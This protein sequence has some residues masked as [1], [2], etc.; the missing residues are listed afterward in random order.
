M[1]AYVVRR[2]LSGLLLVLLL[3]F[4]TFAVYQLI[5]VNPACLRI[6]CG[7]GNRSTPA[8]FAA[9]DHQLGVDRPLPFQYARWV[10]RF[11]RHGSFGTGW[12]GGV[13]VTSTIGHALPITA[14]IVAGGLLLLLLMAI[15]LGCYAALRPRSP[16]D[17]GLL[18]FGVLGLAIHPFVLAIAIKDLFGYAG[19]PGGGYCALTSTANGCGGPAD[20]GAHLVLPWI[21]F[22]LFFLPIYLRMIRVR[23]LE[24]LGEQYVV[25]ARAKGATEQR[26][27]RHHVL[28][29]AM[30]PLL[31]MVAA[32]AGTALTAA[33][34]IELVFG[35]P[36]L[37]QLSVRSLSGQSGG[38][39][40]AMVAG[41]VATVG[42][43]VVLLNV[44][45]DIGRASLDPRVRLQAAGGLFPMPRF[46]RES[47]LARVPKLAYGGIVVAAL[48]AAGVVVYTW[49]NPPSGIVLEPPLRTQALSVN[50]VVPLNGG[51]STTTSPGSIVVRI[52]RATFGKSGWKIDYA[53][54]NRSRTRITEVQSPRGAFGSTGFSLG[55]NFHDGV[56]FVAH[57]ELNAAEFLPSAP[58]SIAAG[59]TF[60]GTFGGLEDVPKNVQY[61]VTFAEYAPA[62]L[63]SFPT[64]V[65]VV[66]GNAP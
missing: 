45:A 12:I 62:N 50:S 5:P 63:E 6:D 4:L 41:I 9:A 26:V 44:L 32:D 18:A 43:T 24:T 40:R 36:G 47:P 64:Y 28:R 15:P 57:R 21:C 65:S 8:D 30:G 14:L 38:Y 2:M 23:M 33:I 56:E 61:S 17:R 10:W 48:A 20:W 22:A 27:I 58:T 37:G 31:P 52:T 42:V 55:Y 11:V 34:Y 7:P 51:P 53:L 25:T 49:P 29:N 59:K 35:L 16:A 46:V 60:R 1:A 19:L 13:D 39:D 54:T 66:V 3:T